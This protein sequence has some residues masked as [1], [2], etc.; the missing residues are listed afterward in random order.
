[1]G[2]ERAAVDMFLASDSK[3]GGEPR[4]DLPSALSALLR[5]GGR[6]PLEV[7]ARGFALK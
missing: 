4:G 5:E 1:M 3:I 2:R 6:G 7:E